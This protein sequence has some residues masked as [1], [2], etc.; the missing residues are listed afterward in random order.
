MH[1]RTH[2]EPEDVE[3]LF[4]PVVAHRLLIEPEFLG[5]RD[6][7]PEE[8]A[9]RVWERCLELAPYPGPDWDGARDP[10]TPR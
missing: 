10:A 1:G 5:D 6:L 9:R 3:Q 4:S 2:V 7:G 8:I